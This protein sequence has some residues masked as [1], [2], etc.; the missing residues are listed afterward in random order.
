MFDAYAIAIDITAHQRLCLDDP[1]CQEADIR[2]SLPEPP[3]NEEEADEIPNR[4]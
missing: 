1:R 2:N 4:P 3:E